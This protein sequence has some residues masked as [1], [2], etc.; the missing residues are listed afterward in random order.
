M[1]LN[2]SQQYAIQWMVS[3]GSEVTQIVKELKI[4]KDLVNKFIEKNCKPN[5]ANSIQTKS[6]PIK[7]KDLMIR[8][9]ASKGN[10]TVAVMTKEASQTAD[11][12]KKSLPNTTN[13]HNNSIHK[14]NE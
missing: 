1:K 6:G 3:Q 11:A 14:I 4:A 13:R 12:F 9:T 8:Q 2:R 7:A 10:N 5:K